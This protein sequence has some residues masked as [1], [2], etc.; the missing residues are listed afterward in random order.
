LSRI[1]DSHSLHSVS[2]IDDILGKIPVERAEDVVIFDPLDI[3]RPVGFNVLE[4]KTIQDR[5]LIIDEIYQIFHQIYD[6]KETG[7][8]IFEQYFR[9]ALAL[10]MGD[11]KRDS[12]SATLLDFV[13]FFIDADFRKYLRD[14][15]DDVHLHDFLKQ[16]EKA[17]G[18]ATLNNV[19]PYITSKFAR[20]Q[21]ST[22]KRILGNGQTT[23]DIEDI[24]NTGRI[25]LIK[26]GKGRFGGV[27]SA[28]LANMIVSRIKLA[29]MKRGELPLSKRREFFIYIDEA[30]NLPA[31]NFMELLAEA[32]KYRLGLVMATQY[33]AQLTKSSIGTRDNLLSALL[34]NV[35][36]TIVFRLGQEDAKKMAASFEP[37]F[38][39]RDIIA[40]PN[41]HGYVRMQQKNNALAPFSIKTIVNKT[42]YNSDLARKIKKLS[43][44]KYGV[45]S[46]LVDATMRRRRS[47][48]KN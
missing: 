47:V 30:H 32:R 44:L 33:A 48:W 10:L 34:G 40:L 31:E 19:T 25:F 41:W 46:S 23:F 13:P 16:A 14:T 42:P 7:G 39:A 36:Q 35:G 2:M 20:L 22:L 37:S 12:F 17:G 6:F 43:S 45:N 29:A 38:G 1:Q 18:E 3:E 8:P 9:G 21:D 5:D 4:W 11:Q 24:M 15:V 26:L 27:T 28:L